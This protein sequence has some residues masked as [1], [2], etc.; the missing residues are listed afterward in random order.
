MELKVQKNP[1][2]IINLAMAR[3]SCIRLKLPDTIVK[4]RIRTKYEQL[5]RTGIKMGTL[6]II[7]MA[8]SVLADC[9]AR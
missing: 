3:F 9:T 7:P 8:L 4:N 5:P 1:V 2:P 6:P